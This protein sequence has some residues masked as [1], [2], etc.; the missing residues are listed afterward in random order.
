MNDMRGYYLCRLSSRLSR[1][2]VLGILVIHRGRLQKAFRSNRYSCTLFP[3]APPWAR[4]F[5]NPHLKRLAAVILN[6][7]Q[8]M[9]LHDTGLPDQGVEIVPNRIESG[10]TEGIGVSM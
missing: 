4:F 2:L 1:I 8:N 9:I 6:F 5:I 7:S 3:I 10:M